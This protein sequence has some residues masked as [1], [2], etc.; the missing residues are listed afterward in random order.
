MKFCQWLSVNSAAAVRHDYHNKH[1]DF[2]VK[3]HPPLDLR[4]LVDAQLRIAVTAVH[5]YYS[6]HN[7][8]KEYENNSLRISCDGGTTYKHIQLPD[9]LY[10]YK[11]LN[12]Y[13]A[14]TLRKCKI[15]N[16][17]MIQ[18]SETT[19]RVSINVGPKIIVDLTQ[20][21]FSKLLGFEKVTLKEGLHESQSPPNLS[22]DLDNVYVHC[23]LTDKS[24]VDGRWGDVIYIFP[25]ARLLPGHPF[26]F[27]E[28]TLLFSEL[29]KHHISS[30]RIYITDVF[31]NYIDLNKAPITVQLLIAA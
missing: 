29:S 5:G 27:N 26:A 30:L 11:D 8:R 6:W 21:E 3:I 23:D 28:K 4:D 1:H 25:T 10:S 18:F 15:E 22:H 31:G 24:L 16:A 2:E 13:I 14:E 17:L 19:Y 7:I 9:G 12:A 20:G